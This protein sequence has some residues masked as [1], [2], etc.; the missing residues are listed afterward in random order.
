MAMSE[1]DVLLPDLRVSNIS[2]PGGLKSGTCSKIRVTVTNSSMAAAKG[3]IPVI[4]FVSQNGQQPSSYVG[5]VQ[6]G[7]GPNA[8]YGKPVWFSNVNIPATG[9]VT[10]K[11][12]VNPDFDIQ[13]SVTNNNTKIIRARVSRSCGS[14]TQPAQGATLTVTAYV[15]GQW[16]YSNY[17]PVPGAHVTIVKSG[18]TYQATAGN[19]GK[20]TFPSIPTGMCSITVTKPGY[21]TGTKSFMMSSYNNNTNVAMVPN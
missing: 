20:A 1:A 7:L 21:Q 2:T 9:N 17:T 3:N 19:N 16:N 4:L 8:N 12:V 11:A 14:T 5:Y 18:Q 13:E 6:G 10:L 15:A